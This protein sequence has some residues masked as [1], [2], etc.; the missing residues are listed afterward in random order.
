MK[1]VV[2]EELCMRC[3]ACVG[4]CPVN[5]MFLKEY[6]LEINDDC[7]SCGQCEKVCPVRAISLEGK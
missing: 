3:G 2:D 1:P 6:T 4:T 5:A 7:T